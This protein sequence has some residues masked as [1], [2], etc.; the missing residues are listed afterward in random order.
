MKALRV[1]QPTQLL[2]PL[3]S[4][5]EVPKYSA[6]I[7]LSS[8]QRRGWSRREPASPPPSTSSQ[9]ERSDGIGSWSRVLCICCAI[10]RTD[11]GLGTHRTGAGL[12]P[13]EQCRQLL[14]GP[15]LRV[16]GAAKILHAVSFQFAEEDRHVYVLVAIF[17]FGVVT[18]PPQI[19]LGG[20]IL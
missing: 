15:H 20:A 5:Q 1:F 12:R 18:A 11:H 19:Q 13:A 6:C 2:S 3:G 14:R 7:P 9:N 4:G 10:S 16:S 17:D 8:P